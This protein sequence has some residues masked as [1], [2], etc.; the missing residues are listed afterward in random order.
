[1]LVA[2]WLALA[3]HLARLTFATTSQ[4]M[5]AHSSSSAEL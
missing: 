2:V 5:R 3:T 4:F 1:M